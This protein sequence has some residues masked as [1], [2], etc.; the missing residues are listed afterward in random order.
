MEGTVALMIPIV[1]FI[2]IGVCIGF[3]MYYRFRSRQEMQLTVRSA[4]DS[5]KEVSP[6][7]IAELTQAL[8]PPSADLRKG[9]VLCAVGAA[10]VVLAF[11][12]GEEEATMP[13]LGASAFPILVG[14]A[15]LT[16]AKIS[17]DN[18]SDT[19]PDRDQDLGRSRP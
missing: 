14:L 9:I 11:V 7:I 3:A 2:T 15:Y 5:G 19:D 10:F 12:L 13:I 18:S 16:L 8:F 4:I 17:R 1:M 6:E